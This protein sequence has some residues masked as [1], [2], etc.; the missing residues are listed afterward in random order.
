VNYLDQDEGDDPA[1]GV[2]G[3]NY[4]RLRALKKTYDP[5]NFFHQNVNIKPGA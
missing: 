4:A 2:Y 5:D 1:A 3:Q